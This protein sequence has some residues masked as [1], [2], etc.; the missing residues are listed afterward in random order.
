MNTS[1]DHI[2]VHKDR[3]LIDKSVD[4]NLAQRLDWI[5]Q[6]DLSLDR[7]TEDDVRDKLSAWLATDAQDEMSAST[8]CNMLLWLIQEYGRLESHL[9][10]LTGTNAP[11]PS[12]T[13]PRRRLA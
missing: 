12:L 1:M 6:Q 11:P 8:S 7:A 2:D 9:C 3:M 5:V 4:E 10:S 13:E